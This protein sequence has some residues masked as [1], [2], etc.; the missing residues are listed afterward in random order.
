MAEE[1]KLTGEQLFL[2][3]AFPCADTM[4]IIGK[5]DEEHFLELD[6]LVKSNGQ[7]RRRLFPFCFPNAFRKLRKYA[8]EN[9]LKRWALSTV[10]D[11]WRNHH[12]HEGD[13]RVRRCTVVEVDDGG[14]IITVLCGEEQFA[15]I[16]LYHLPILLDNVVYVHRKVV[17]E[18]EGF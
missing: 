15:T 5:I 7:P 8:E 1:L 6:Q 16:N 9:G 4:L 12:D 11:L 18:I 17:V 14:V 10:Q 3:Y 2:R 13:C